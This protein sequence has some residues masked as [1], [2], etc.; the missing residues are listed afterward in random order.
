MIVRLSCV[1]PESNG[2]SPLWYP[3]FV[4]VNK[5]FA[6]E[7]NQS[8]TTI[9]LYGRHGQKIASFFIPDGR[10]GQKNASFFIFYGRHGQKI[11]S[12]FILYGR[13]G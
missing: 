13:H 12:F 10:H 7:R 2:G 3:H 4:A 5:L 9:V 11:A 8:V 6:M 1:K